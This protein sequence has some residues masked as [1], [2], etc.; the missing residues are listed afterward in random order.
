[1]QI[2]VGGLDHPD[3]RAL[4]AVHVAFGRSHTPAENAHVLPA[5]GLAVS[6]ITFWSAWEGGALAGFAALKELA[7]HHGELKSMRTAPAFLR[8]GVAKLLLDR[9]IAVARAR[10][11]TQLSL[12]TGTAAAFAP[13][14]RL[15]EAA[16]FVDCAAFGGYP[17]SPHNRFMT[18]AL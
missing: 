18:L 14:N 12:E 1:M 9:V 13:A 15:Y 6:A 16:G 11:Y 3:V 5:D 8:R 7:G 2:R 10:G 17:A 4:L